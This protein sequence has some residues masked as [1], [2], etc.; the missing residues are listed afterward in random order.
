[1]A[2]AA[3]MLHI[4]GQCSVL[5][6]L[7]SDCLVPIPTDKV[8]DI[9]EIEDFL[10]RRLKLRVPFA[11]VLPGG[12]EYV[13]QP[14][15]EEVLIVPAFPKGTRVRAREM[16][17]R[18]EL[19]GAAGTVVMSKNGRFGVAFDSGEKGMLT[20]ANLQAVDKIADIAAATLK[21]FL[22]D[23]E[24]NE[25]DS[26]V[27]LE[28][29][30]VY[31][32]PFSMLTAPGPY[33]PGLGA[34]APP[35]TYVQGSCAATVI[36]QRTRATAR[37]QRTAKSQVR[38]QW[39]GTA[40]IA[41]ST[42]SRRPPPTQA[43]RPKRVSRM[44][45][46]GADP[47]RQ[48]AERQVDPHQQAAQRPELNLAMIAASG[49]GLSLTADA[50][51]AQQTALK[52]LS[53]EERRQRMEQLRIKC[54]LATVRELGEALARC[55]WMVEAAAVF[56]ARTAPP[57]I[58]YVASAASYSAVLALVAV[59]HGDC[60]QIEKPVVVEVLSCRKCRRQLA[61][62]DMLADHSPPTHAKKNVFRRNKGP[63]A[64]GVCQSLWLE[65][66]EVD[67]ADAQ[68]AEGGMGTLSCPSCG[69]KLGT[70]NWSGQQCSCGTWETPGFQIQ[71][72]RVDRNPLGG[73]QLPTRAPVRERI[74]EDDDGL[75]DS[76]HDRF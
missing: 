66:G 22:K 42:A 23:T 49:G 69:T 51:A 36:S 26:W 24:V 33:A 30:P 3:D 5:P 8:G 53:R 34:E 28:P 60:E 63:S 67:W 45:T 43:I 52:P 4:R 6:A 48:H 21:D 64:E 70:F 62:T 17:S 74:V 16:K 58:K 41:D 13:G 46:K 38:S 27:E 65:P 31:N 9:S 50:L 76:P 73:H 18:P 39:G 1:M 14:D 32:D 61:T 10:Q 2:G 25:D 40:S 71:I 59:A 47:I 29:E 54:P 44:H 20:P 7:E 15:T 75:T 72:A 56:I 57:P 11:L 37:T 68:A 12:E 35:K 19:N 55:A